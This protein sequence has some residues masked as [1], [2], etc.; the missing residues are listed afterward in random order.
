[1]YAGRVISNVP[2]IK[3]AVNA[4]AKNDFL[5]KSFGYIPDNKSS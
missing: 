1:M 5:I 2:A 3:P 4:L